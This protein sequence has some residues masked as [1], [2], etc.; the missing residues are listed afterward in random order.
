MHLCQLAYVG[1][2]HLIS[3]RVH[4]EKSHWSELGWSVTQFLKIWDQSLFTKLQIPQF[5][6]HILMHLFNPSFPVVRWS[7]F[8]PACKICTHGHQSATQFTFMSM[9][10][11]QAT[12]SPHPLHRKPRYCTPF[13]LGCNPYLASTPQVYNGHNNIL[14]FSTLVSL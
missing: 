6:M 5:P 7:L 3:S 4:G 14:V 12:P 8:Q 9:L 2:N 1:G 13:S 11:G 10:R